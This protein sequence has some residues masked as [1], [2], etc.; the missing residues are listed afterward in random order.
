MSHYSVLVISTEGIEDVDNQLEPFNENIEMEPYVADEVDEGDIKRFMDNYAVVDYG[1]AMIDNKGR[2][3]EDLYEEY[4]SDWN[5]NQWEKQSDGK[6]ARVSTYNPDS[7]WD[8]YEVGGRWCGQLHIKDEAVAEVAPISP[9]HGWKSAGN[10]TALAEKVAQQTGDHARADQIDWEAKRVEARTKAE[11][12]WDAVAELLG[13]TEKGHITQPK[14][15]YAECENLHGEI[16]KARD[17]YWA[18][19]LM[20]I[21][22]TK[23]QGDIVGWSTGIADFDRTREEYT[24]AAY[25]G[26]VTFYACLKDGEWHEAGKMG[27]FGMSHADDDEKESFGQNFY[28]AFI[29]DLPDHA[30]LTVIDCHI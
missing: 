4:G 9:S 18:Q 5:G 30:L 23:L 15:T 16:N 17:E 3:F 27:W 20:K 24:Q 26:A 7:K 13:T 2:T 8:W 29:K 6:Y 1:E 12:R 22:S 11:E 28:D 14:Y 21:W 19:P 25:N 10:E